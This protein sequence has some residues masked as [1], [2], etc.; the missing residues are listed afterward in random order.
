ML[1]A[2]LGLLVALVLLV[3]ANRVSAVWLKRRWFKL[4]ARFMEQGA[5][6]NIDILFLGDSITAFWQ[7]PWARRLWESTYAVRRSANFAIGGDTTENILWRIRDGEL[8]DVRPKVVVLLAG[9]NDLILRGEPAN[10]VQG[11]MDILSEVQA[12]L[13]D[14]KVLVLAIFP[15]AQ[16]GSRRRKLIDEANAMLCTRLEGRSRTL[17]VDIGSRFLKSDGTVSRTVMPDRVH[18]ST[19]GYRIWGDAMEAPLQSLLQ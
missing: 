9:I 8:R 2:A 14:T 4:H 11:I 12:L 3:V 15:S 5:Q 19:R 13:P 7:S 18:L 10:V 17:F 6:G 16:P 1:N